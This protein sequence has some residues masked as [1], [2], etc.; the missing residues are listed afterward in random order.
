MP[1]PGPP[2]LGPV[3]VSREWLGEPSKTSP[4]ESHP[5][6]AGRRGVRLGR[7]G[8]VATLGVSRATS[9]PNDQ[10]DVLIEVVPLCSNRLTTPLD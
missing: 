3:Q 2:Q 5:S 7:V 4:R 10:R 8:P 9:A 6:N 1:C